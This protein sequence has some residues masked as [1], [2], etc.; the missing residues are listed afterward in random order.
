MELLR[1]KQ[2]SEAIKCLK[3][4]RIDPATIQ[5]FEATGEVSTCSCI[6]STPEK[7]PDHILEMIRELE[8]EYGF[9]VYLNV[10][11]ATFLGPIHNLFFVGKYEEEW[12]MQ[13]RD[14]EEGYALVYA[15]NLAYPDCSEMGSIAFRRTE[16]GG[17]L[18]AH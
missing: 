5:K 9:L 13:F 3:Q 6:H 17:I 18:R 8:R 2:R 4:L 11:S 10:H 12:E 15:L 1:E 16:N 14:L 7:T